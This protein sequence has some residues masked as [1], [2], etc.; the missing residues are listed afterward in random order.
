[1]PLGDFIPAP[2]GSQPGAGG[3]KMYL[4]S[5]ATLKKI[6]QRVEGDPSQFDVA[7]TPESRVYRL[8][9]ISGGSSE[10]PDSG[11]YWYGSVGVSYTPIV[12]ST[13]Q[14]SMTFTNGRL[15]AVAGW[16]GPGDTE[17]G[18]IE[19][20]ADTPGSYTFEITDT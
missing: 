1:M 4:I 9:D 18:P 17:G 5:E 7:E 20:T 14:F 13:R 6:L 10:T 12:G 2:P 15:T 19:G 11:N 16:T 3:G 8:R